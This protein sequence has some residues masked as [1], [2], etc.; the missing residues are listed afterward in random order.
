MTSKASIHVW[1]QNGKIFKSVSYVK[2]GE[3]FIYDENEKLL[4]KRSGLSKLQIKQIETYI[5]RYGLKKLPKNGGP[6]KY[7]G[8]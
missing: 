8:K 3:I 1:V 5:K 6:F 7:L 4:L 2:E